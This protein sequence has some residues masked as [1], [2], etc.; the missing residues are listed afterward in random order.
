[1]DVVSPR[2][3]VTMPTFVE[4][5]WYRISPERTRAGYGRRREP[6]LVGVGPV[7]VTPPVGEIAV[8]AHDRLF[9]LP[10]TPI[11]EYLRGWITRVEADRSRQTIA[12]TIFIFQTIS[13]CLRIGD[14]S[15][16]EKFVA[17]ALRRAEGE[18]LPPGTMEQAGD[19]TKLSD[20]IV[21]TSWKTFSPSAWIRS[22]ATFDLY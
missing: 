14:I 5:Q 8:R 4:E 13:E 18:F 15:D 10:L 11:A 2:R 1:V 9:I 22:I 7:D 20:L 19:L 12:A 3:W 21:N 6:L 17:R 16:V